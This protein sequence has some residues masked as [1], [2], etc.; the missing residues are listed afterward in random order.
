M[1]KTWR[2]VLSFSRRRFPLTLS[3]TLALWLGSASLDLALGRGPYDNVRTAE[4]WAW[5]QIKL[6]KTADFNKR[7]GT[8]NLDPKEEKDKRWQDDCRKL[9]GRFVVDL[10]TETSLR[11]VVPFEG[12]RI[13]GA[14][15]VGNVD[16]G[17]TK[18]NRPIEIV[19][20]RIEGVITLDHAHT[21]SLISLDGSL[22]NDDV[23]ADG[24]HS[25]SGL[26]RMTSPSSGKRRMERP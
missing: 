19:L 22:M 5:S 25:E 1:P 10:L 8:P 9:S 23:I 12:A 18:L 3:G 7:C 11:D 21:D 2:A 17:D 15:I 24:L 13:T 26:K 6:G 16:L 20:S 14:R 4:G